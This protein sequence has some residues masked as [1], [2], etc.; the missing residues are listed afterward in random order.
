MYGTIYSTLNGKPYLW[1]EWAALDYPCHR[2]VLLNDINGD[3]TI[4][5]LP[6]NSQIMLI[7]IT[8]FGKACFIYE[9]MLYTLSA[10]KKG[11]YKEMIYANRTRSTKCYYCKK[12]PIDED[13][14]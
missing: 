9:E 6:P 13:L 14:H 11:R 5:Y 12:R 7:C 1:V 2:T 4:E 8:D 3:V 10:G